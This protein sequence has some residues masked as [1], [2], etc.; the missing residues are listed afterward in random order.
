MIGHE[1][2]A[3]HEIDH[4]RTL[5]IVLPGT[6]NIMIEQKKERL[7]QYAENVW[8]I[9]YGTDEEK[10]ALAIEKTEHFFNTLGIATRLRDYDVPEQTIG[11]IVARMK[12]RKWKLGE[13][14]EVTPAR[15]E[16][17]LKSRI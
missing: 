6:W 1:L 11:K 2:T 13:N 4:A 8:G 10:V 9:T 14:K 3:F 16:E 15:V 5:A 7:L 12:E 17:I